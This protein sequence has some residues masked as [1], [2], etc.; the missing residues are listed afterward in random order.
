MGVFVK[1]FAQ[2]LVMLRVIAHFRANSQNPACFQLL[3]AHL[4]HLSVRPA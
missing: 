4:G 3:M 1:D 2:S